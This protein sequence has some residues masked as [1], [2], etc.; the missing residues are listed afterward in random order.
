MTLQDGSAAKA[1]QIEFAIGD[2]SRAYL[3]AKEDEAEAKERRQQAENVLMALVQNQK[4]EGTVSV[5][6]AGYRVSITNKVN[7]TL[8]QKSVAK[9]I[10]ELPDEQSAVRIEYKLS[11]TG[12]RSM[13]EYYPE[14]ASIL[15]RAITTTPARAGIKVSEVDD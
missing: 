1:A 7:R 3:K 12:L 11:L 14:A 4:A 10:R 13:T 2:A 6:A 15:S 8:D 9:L 5:E